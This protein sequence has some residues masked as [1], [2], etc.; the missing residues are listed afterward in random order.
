VWPGIGLRLPWPHLTGALRRRRTRGISLVFHE[1]GSL[2]G[3]AAVTSLGYRVGALK[4]KH[5]PVLL[6]LVAG[7]GFGVVALS[8]RLIT[9]RRGRR[10]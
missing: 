1:I 7:F 6:G 3:V 2:I 9:E 10:R 8:A 4:V 5:G